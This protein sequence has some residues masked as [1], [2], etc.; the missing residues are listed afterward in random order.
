MFLHVRKVQRKIPIFDHKNASTKAYS[1]W[2]IGLVE[3]ALIIFEPFSPNFATTFQEISMQ[4]SSDSEFKLLDSS[5]SVETFLRFSVYPYENI[6]DACERQH[7][8]QVI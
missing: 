3:K 5:R 8:I 1:C 4:T 7:S 6:P 2:K